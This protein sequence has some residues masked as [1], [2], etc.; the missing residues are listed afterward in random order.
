MRAISH[1]LRKICTLEVSLKSTYLRLHPH[2]I[3]ADGRVTSRF[4]E[5]SKPGDSGL[6]F[7]NRSE[8]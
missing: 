4:R 1:E 7:S 6:D 5:V 8:I 3:G 2:L